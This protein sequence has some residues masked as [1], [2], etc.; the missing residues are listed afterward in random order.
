MT[1]LESTLSAA[2]IRHFRNATGVIEEK[3][4]GGTE[5]QPQYGVRYVSMVRYDVVWYRLIP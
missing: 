3:S 4:V 1:R 5:S 2:V